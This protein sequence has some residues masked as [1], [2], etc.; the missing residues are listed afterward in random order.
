MSKKLEGK[1]ALVTGG[2]SGIGLAT[3]KRFVAEGAFVYITGRRKE[4][5]EAA[6]KEIG[7][8]VVG[9]QGDVS[10]LDDLDR[11]YAQ[12][13]Q[14][15]GRVDVVF[16][17]AGG[18]EFVPLGQITE[19]HFDKTFNTNVK[20]LV[21]TVQKALP[22]MPDGGAIVLNGSIVSIKGFPAFGVYNATK[23]A[24]RSFA[25]TWTNDLKDRKIRVNVVSPGPIDTP[26]VD[27]LAKTAEEAAQIKAGLASQVPL[28]RIG[29]PDE[30]AKVAVFLASEDA[31]FV[32]GVELFVDG[33]LAQ[34]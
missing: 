8:N 4:N 32:A 17:N 2:N 30:I 18:G 7:S 13:K 26:G 21:F 20:G 15:K 19:E 3:A 11:V 27:G 5:L 25:R 29:E 14:E 10:R 33:G 6:V 31:S 23:A 24:V 1:I 9:I 12:I 34:V 28:G 16:A 22:L